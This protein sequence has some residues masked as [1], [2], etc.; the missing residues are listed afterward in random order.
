MIDHGINILHLCAP[1]L[2]SLIGVA[3]A[4]ALTIWSDSDVY[5]PRFSLSRK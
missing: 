5:E 4:I 1:V 3:A 2:L